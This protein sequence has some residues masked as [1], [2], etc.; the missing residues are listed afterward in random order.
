MIRRLK[1]IWF[2]LMLLLMGVSILWY[3]MSTNSSKEEVLIEFSLLTMLLTFPVGYL[4]FAFS[5]FIA[6]V[7]NYDAGGVVYAV[8][9]WGLSLLAGYYQWF[10]FLPYMVNKIR[11]RNRG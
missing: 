6:W 10:K 9:L 1:V 5:G 7:L 2:F 4:I 11:G 3:G 8:S